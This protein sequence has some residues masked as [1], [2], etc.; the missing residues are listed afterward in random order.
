MLPDINVITLV[1]I[2]IGLFLIFIGYSED[3]RNSLLRGLI[4]I[5]ISVFLPVFLK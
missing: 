2:F 3:E 4:I 5:I 1:G